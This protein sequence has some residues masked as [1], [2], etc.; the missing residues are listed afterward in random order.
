MKPQEL[1][2]DFEARKLRA[3]NNLRPI[4][5]KYTPNKLSIALGFGTKSYTK[6]LN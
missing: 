5:I 6:V 2:H 1:K 4:T 3:Q